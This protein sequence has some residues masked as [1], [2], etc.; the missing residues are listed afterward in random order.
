MLKSAN[1]P[2]LSAQ[3]FIEGKFDLPEGGRWTE[4]HS[5]VVTTFEPPDDV[6]GNV[7]RNL[8]RLLAEYSQTEPEGYA[9]FELGF[10]VARNPDTIYFPPISY[11]TSGTRFGETDEIAT[12]RHPV[13]VVEIASTN[14]RRRGMAARVQQYLDWHVPTIWVADSVAREIHVFG[15]GVAPRQYRG[16]QVLLGGEGLQNFQTPVA[17]LFS[18]PEWW[19]NATKQKPTEE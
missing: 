6:H 19:S 11:I 1:H 8:S 2:P 3:E 9:C 16:D 4:L 10:V 17:P 18:D 12:E 15:P 13:L 7:V 5:G 14:D